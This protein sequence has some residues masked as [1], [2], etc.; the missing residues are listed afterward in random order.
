MMKPTVIP[1]HSGE[2]LQEAVLRARALPGDV[3][4]SLAPGEYFLET[5]VSLF[6]KDSGLTI[7][8]PGGAVLTGCKALGRIPWEPYRDGIFRARLD[9]IPLSRAID[10]V[11][12]NNFPQ[13]MARFP[14]EE[15]GKVPLGGAAD[16]KTIRER[17]AG[18]RQPETGRLRALHSFGWGGNDYQITGRDGS[19]PFGLA[20]RW[21]GDNNRG[22][23]P[24]LE[25]AVVEN[26][27]EELDAPGGVVLCPGGAGPL[28]L[29][30]GGG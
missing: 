12:V 2:N 13:T 30:H 14:N 17:A 26:I 23:E 8:S 29:S 25:A 28:S 19:S 16:A 7:A 6:K 18:W 20:L 9:H 4:L 10:G 11:T 15:K 21:M 5:P 27:F 24:S 3:T 22:G 1:L